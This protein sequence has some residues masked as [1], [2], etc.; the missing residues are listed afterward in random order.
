MECV[1]IQAEN[2]RGDV[3]PPKKKETYRLWRHS[4]QTIERLSVSWDVVE[5]TGSRMD[6]WQFSQQVC[7][8]PTQIL[9]WR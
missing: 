2:G 5:D 6:S 7:R 4:V 1:R 9:Q 8:V 3:K